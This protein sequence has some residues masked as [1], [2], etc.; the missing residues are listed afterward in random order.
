MDQYSD[1]FAARLE[2][3]ETPIDC[4]VLIRKYKLCFR[5]SYVRN[6]IVST[7]CYPREFCNYNIVRNTEEKVADR[8]C[9][10]TYM[11]LGGSESSIDYR[12]RSV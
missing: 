3:P 12:M 8:I 11:V 7:I 1:V 6:D 4:V 2:L 5:L 9:F 10:L